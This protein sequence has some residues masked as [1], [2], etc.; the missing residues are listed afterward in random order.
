MNSDGRFPIHRR[1][2]VLV[3]VGCLLLGSGTL[4]FGQAHYQGC[5]V[6]G[7]SGGEP[8]QCRVGPGTFY[9]LT[10]NTKGSAGNYT[11]IFD[12]A[13]YSAIS[14]AGTP[15]MTIDTTVG[16]VTV[17]YNGLV[18]NGVVV[19]NTSGVNADL[20]VMVE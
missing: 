14:V 9:G 17:I 12:L 15:I 11:Y 2:T 3:L 19:W 20:T 7:V 1:L 4:L 18:T 6:F 13:S 10:I 5:H 8:V 16:P